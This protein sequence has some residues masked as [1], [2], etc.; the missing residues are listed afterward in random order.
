MGPLEAADLADRLNGFPGLR[1]RFEHAEPNSAVRVLGPLEVCARQ[2]QAGRV[3]LAGDAA[4]YLDPLTGEGL[5]GA[6]VS[7]ALAGQL[8]ASG[9][10]ESYP[11]L[12]R[13]AF[14]LGP[15]M[16]RAFQWTLRRPRLVEFLGRRMARRPRLADAFIRVVGHVAPPSALLRA[17]LP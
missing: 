9:R 4:G 8:A 3:L 17:L 7:G 15:R 12:L 11:R 16:N 13:R 14:G 5:Y 1:D 10:P 2:P 6:L